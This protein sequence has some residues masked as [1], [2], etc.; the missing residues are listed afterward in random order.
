MAK[1]VGNSDS[2]ALAYVLGLKSAGTSGLNNLLKTIRKF[3]SIRIDFQTL[4]KL[5]ATIR[6][7]KSK[8][9]KLFMSILSNI[10]QKM[11]YLRDNKG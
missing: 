10:F 7:R 5:T 4:I 8:P 3:M 11:A 9:V 1:I 2:H 6:K